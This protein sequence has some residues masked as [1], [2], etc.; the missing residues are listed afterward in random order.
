MTEWEL[1]QIC[2]RT[3]CDCKCL[4]CPIMARYQRSQLGYDEDTDDEE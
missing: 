3:A 4:L 2:E 1:D